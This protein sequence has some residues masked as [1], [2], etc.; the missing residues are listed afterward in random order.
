MTSEEFFADEY[1]MN[2]PNRGHALIINNKSFDRS[3]GL[4]ER[5]GTDQDAIALSQRFEEMGFTTD[6]YQNLQCKEMLQ[7]LHKGKL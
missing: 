6:L 5:T 3:L 2:Y 1:K 4:G 7:I